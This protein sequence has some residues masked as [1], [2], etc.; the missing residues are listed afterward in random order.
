MY[1]ILS[2]DKNRSKTNREPTRPRAV[3][4]DQVDNLEKSLKSPEPNEVEQ[5][6]IVSMEC[7]IEKNAESVVNMTL[8][9]K[10][11]DK[12]NRQLTTELNEDDIPTAMVDELIKYGLINGLDKDKLC[13]LIE[14]EQRAYAIRLTA[15]AIDKPLTEPP[16]QQQPIAT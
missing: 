10:L 15:E 5:R 16:A 4:P 8:T 11:E 13:T 6:T 9:I 3:S 12:M 2:L 14:E 7:Q 1:P